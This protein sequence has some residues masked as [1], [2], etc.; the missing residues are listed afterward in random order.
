MKIVANGMVHHVAKAFFYFEVF[1]PTN[2][3][4]FTL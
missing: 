3:T 4:K 1:L 2:M